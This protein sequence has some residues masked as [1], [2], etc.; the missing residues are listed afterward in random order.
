[1]LIGKAGLLDYI[2]V[3]YSILFLLGSI[4]LTLVLWLQERR[5]AKG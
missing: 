4:A 2:I 3:P 1:M 5:R